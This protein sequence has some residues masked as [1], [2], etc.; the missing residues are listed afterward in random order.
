MDL[1][2]SVFI[3]KRMSGPPMNIILPSAIGGAAVLGVLAWATWIIT[4]S[5]GSSKTAASLP[6]PDEDTVSMASSRRSTVDSIPEV[7][8]P[9]YDFT[10]KGM[11]SQPSPVPRRESFAS[12]T[13]T[14]G[15][16]RRRRRGGSRNRGRS[17]RQ[18]ARASSAA[19]RR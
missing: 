12:G 17:R 1:L 19:S 15:G 3:F 5:S 13:S 16:R 9:T 10:F 6:S 8:D 14:V 18:R 7:P 4:Q 11:P 2:K